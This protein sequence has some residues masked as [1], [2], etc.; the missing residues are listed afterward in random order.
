MKGLRRETI[1][2]RLEEAALQLADADDEAR[3]LYHELG[4]DDPETRLAQRRRR[5][6]RD[7]IAGLGRSLRRRF[8]EE[9]R[10]RDEDEDRKE[11][12]KWAGL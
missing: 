9:E 12:E 5:E 6:A 7:R 8:D 11:R 1:R 4:K 10:K 3:D 2:V